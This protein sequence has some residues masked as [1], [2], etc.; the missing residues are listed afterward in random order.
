[1]AKYNIYCI[2]VAHVDTK[3]EVSDAFLVSVYI[4]KDVMSPNSFD[5]Y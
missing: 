4:D 1:M 3:M 5:K 2:G